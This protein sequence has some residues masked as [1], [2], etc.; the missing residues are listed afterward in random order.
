MSGARCNTIEHIQPMRV[1]DDAALGLR[2]HL[3]ANGGQL[4]PMHGGTKV[5]LLMI[6]FIKP[7]Q[8]VQAPVAAD[9]VRQAVPGDGAMGDHPIAWYHEFDGGRAFYTALGHRV[10]LYTD[11]QYTQHLLGGIQWAAGL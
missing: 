6:P 3:R 9:R 7:E 10:E 11:P 2:E 8:V 1:R 5:V 4:C